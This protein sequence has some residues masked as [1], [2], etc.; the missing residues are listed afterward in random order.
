[1][2]LTLDELYFN[3]SQSVKSQKVKVCIDHLNFVIAP[4]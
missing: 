1:M 4:S 2:T 3:P